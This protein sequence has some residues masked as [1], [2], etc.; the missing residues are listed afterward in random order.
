MNS[1]LYPVLS[2]WRGEHILCS[3]VGEIGDESNKSNFKRI[4]WAAHF[5]P[6]FTSVALTALCRQV[7]DIA[8]RCSKS[9]YKVSFDFFLTVSVFIML[10]L[11]LRVKY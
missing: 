1:I 11:S 10:G 6:P 4:M 9:T 7:V 3:A 8:N 2:F 5:E